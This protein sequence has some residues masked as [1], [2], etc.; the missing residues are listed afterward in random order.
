MNFE[1]EY[2]DLGEYLRVTVRGP[3]VEKTA[4]SLFDQAKKEAQERG[5]DRILFDVTAWQ[6]P[7][8][9]V[10]FQTGVYLAEVFGAQCKIAALTLRENLTRL[11]EDAAV[12][13]GAWFQVFTDEDSAI[14]WL[15][16]APT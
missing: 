2:V 9:I 3:W 14:G 16:D 12:N 10:R 5:H 8:E 4:R 6:K 15:L 7:T 13:R 1:V 11:G